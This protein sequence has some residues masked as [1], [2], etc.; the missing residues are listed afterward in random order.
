V[1][2]VIHSDQHRFGFVDGDSAFAEIEAQLAQQPE[3]LAPMISLHG[4]VNGVAPPGS[5][6]DQP[7]RHGPIKA[8]VTMPLQISCLKQRVKRA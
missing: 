7:P 4:K 1:E 2:V 3:I 6:A 5:S 8:R